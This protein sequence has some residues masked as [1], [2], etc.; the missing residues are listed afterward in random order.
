[1]F[2]WPL[3]PGKMVNIK[4]FTG[5]DDPYEAPL[6]PEIRL[7]TVNHSAE[8]NARMILN[9]LIEQGFVR[10]AEREVL[11]TGRKSGKADG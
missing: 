4:G 1:M 10:T 9:Y 7:D 6:H 11:V 2:V 3:L 5:I 8:E